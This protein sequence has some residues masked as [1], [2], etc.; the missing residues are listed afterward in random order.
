MGIFKKDDFVIHSSGVQAI[1]LSTHELLTVLCRDGSVGIMPA[2]DFSYP[3]AFKAG[4]YVR[5]VDS[6]DEFGGEVG[7][8]VEDDG[9]H[10]E[11]MPYLVSFFDEFESENNFSASELL[12]WIP[13]VGEIV[14]VTNDDDEP[15]TVISVDGEF[16]RIKFE[17]FPK[18]QTWPLS[19]LEPGEEFEDDELDDGG[20][21]NEFK[22]DDEV[23]YS[24]PFFSDKKKAIVL[25]VSDTALTVH[26][27]E[28]H[29][30]DGTF[31]KD[32]FSK[33]A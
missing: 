29:E 25:A 10:E 7:I 17:E 31:D 32:F 27:P 16:A 28:D 20:P 24:N 33:A 12:P 22:V 23:D 13:E 11:N 15:G 3:R 30:L 9:D 14:F 4:D 5:V 18:P 1:V 2:S 26:F 6:D 8:V 21:Y 19:D